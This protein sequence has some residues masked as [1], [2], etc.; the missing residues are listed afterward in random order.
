MLLPRSLLE[1]YDKLPKM[2]RRDAPAKLPQA[3]LCSLLKQRETV[4]AAGDG[5]EWNGIA[6]PSKLQSCLFHYFIFM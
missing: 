5:V 4:M 6:Y 2:R 1:A 3:T